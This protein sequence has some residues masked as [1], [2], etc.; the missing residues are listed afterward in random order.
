MTGRPGWYP[1]GQICHPPELPVY[2]KNVYD[3]KPIMGVPN[4]AE[5]IRIHAVLHAARK[6][7]E[8]PA[9]MDPSLLM[10]LADHLFDVQM[11]RYRSKYSLITFPSVRVL[12]QLDPRFVELRV[13]RYIFTSDPPDHLSTKLESVSSASTNE[14]MIKVQ[15]ILLN[16]PEMRRFP[17]M[18]DAHVNMEL[19][20]HLFDLQMGVFKKQYL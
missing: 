1:P 16:Y 17:S 2:L 15:D 14:Q 5:V 6:L 8:V 10:G 12:L 19:S 13:E 9:M 3:L 4:D 7:S 18:F 20:Q 11:A